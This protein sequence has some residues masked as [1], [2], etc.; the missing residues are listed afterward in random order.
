[1]FDLNLADMYRYRIRRI[2]HQSLI[3]L[4]LQDGDYLKGK[5]NTTEECLK[6]EEKNVIELTGSNGSGMSSDCNKN[7]NASHFD[8]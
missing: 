3:F 6:K 7:N 8:G 4:T 2:I 5:K 1:M